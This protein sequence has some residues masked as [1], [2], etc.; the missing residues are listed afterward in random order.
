MDSAR[1]IALVTPGFPRDEA[2]TSCI[3]PLQTAL[4]RLRQRRPVGTIHNRHLEDPFDAVHALTVFSEDRTADALAEL[5]D[6][7]QAS[8]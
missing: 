8:R 4:R 3:P 2:D 6:H 1:H 5:D 7:S